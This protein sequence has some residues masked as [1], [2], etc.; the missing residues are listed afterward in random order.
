MQTASRILQFIRTA[1]TDMVW[2]RC[3]PACG[4]TLT[5]RE[6]CLCIS[7]I[8]RLPRTQLHQSDFNE[9]HHKLGSH[10]R[11]DKAMAWFWYYRGNDL[12]SIIIDAK[13]HDTPRLI[14]DAAAE[15][16]GELTDEGCNPASFA[17]LTVSVPMH[18]SK[19]IARGYNQAEWIADGI[20][21]ACG[22]PIAHCLEATRRHRTQT[23]LSAVERRK[24]LQ[25]SISLRR[26]DI[27]AGRRIL[28]V[29]D[30]ITTGATMI[31]AVE[32]LAQGN[33]ASISILTLGAAKKI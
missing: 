30:I 25:G 1:L 8:Y 24:N 27:V 21:R 23:R 20:R 12:T 19:R 15:Y 18:W 31:A 14:R 5:Q 6:A 11:I 3:C 2:P 10:T 26:P 16:V 33:P 29:D 13:Y 17:D 7:C 22:L 9:L 28:L 4:R 32:A